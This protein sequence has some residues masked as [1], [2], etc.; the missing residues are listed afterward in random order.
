MR[1]LRAGDPGQIGVYRLTGLLGEGGQGSVYRGEAPDGSPVAVKLLHARFGEDAKAR[2][3]FAAELSHAQ[4][5]A[6]FCTARV[7]DADLEGDQPYIVS[8][9]VGGP[10]LAEAIATAGPSQGS[11]L[12][13]IAIATVT[14]LAAIHEA[15]IVHRDFKPNNVIM[16]ADGPRVIDFGIARALDATGTLSSAI[17]GTPA[18]MAP[19]QI[20]GG[21]IGP[22]A[23]IFAWACTVAYAA[24]GATPFGRDSIPTVMHRILN[25]EPDLRGMTSPLRDLVSACLAKDA[26]DRPTARE[27]LL[28]LLGGNESASI[29]QTLLDEGARATSPPLASPDPRP[30]DQHDRPLEVPHADASMRPVGPLEQKPLWITRRKVTRSMALAAVLLGLLTA[31]PWGRIVQTGL[32]LSNTVHDDPVAGVRTIWGILT[33]VMA[34]TALCIAISDEFG[35]RVSAVWAAVPGL[36]ALALITTFMIRKADLVWLSTHTSAT[37]HAQM[38]QMGFDITSSLSPPVYISLAMAV[39]VT[40]LA[41]LSRRFSESTPVS[42]GPAEGAVA[43]SH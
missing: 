28:D 35:R 3:R 25:E 5:V 20:A 4:R 2:S 6:P 21:V 14:A 8:E 12:D 42:S 32:L 31:L 26:A 41:L 29:A 16:G 10:S 24:S 30:R 15:G 39:V 36:L 19:E 37:T 1:E 33:A 40:A 13:R 7:L 43:I 9:F 18:Y 11:A 27:V 17:I 38:R 34:V 23:D 22:A